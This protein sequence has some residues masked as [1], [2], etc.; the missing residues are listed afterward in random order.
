MTL[1]GDRATDTPRGPMTIEIKHFPS[2]RQAATA[3][4]GAIAADLNAALANLPRAL[5]LVSGGRSPV[6]F[7]QILAKQPLAWERIDISV[8]DERSVAPDGPDANATL[9]CSSL[10]VGAARAARWIPL[11]PV[12]IFAVAAEPWQAAEQAALHANSNPLLAVADVVV[13]G[14][15]DDGHTASLF[16]DAPQWPQARTTRTRYVAVQ[17]QQA[18]HARVTL[19]LHALRQQRRCYLWITGAEKAATLARLQ[20]LCSASN[21]QVTPAA[22]AAAGPVACLIADSKSFLEAYCSTA[23]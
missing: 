1:C 23:D 10:M 5:L 21:Q 14:M 22:L 20:A 19:S 17:P 15:G 3:L 4:A 18:P 11:M 9:V 12:E 7:F 8:V 16:S 2:S 6:Q 13:L